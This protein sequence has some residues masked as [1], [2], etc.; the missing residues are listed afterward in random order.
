MFFTKLL[1]QQSQPQPPQPVTV[2]TP[3]FFK[4]VET[5]TNTVYFEDYYDNLS[6]YIS[7]DGATWTTWQK[8]YGLF[9][10]TIAPNAK[11]YIKAATDKGFIGNSNLASYFRLGN[12]AK[13]A[14]GGNIMSLIFNNFSTQTTITTPY[15]FARIF[16]TLKITDASELLLPATTVS[17]NCYQAL[18]ADTII[19]YAPTILPAT[20]LAQSCYT[21][22]FQ[23]C[24]VL[25]TAPELPATVMAQ[26]CYGAMFYGCSALRVAPELPAT[27]LAAGCYAQMFQGCVTLTNAPEL[28]AENL[29][30]ACYS[31]MFKGCSNLT[32]IKCMAS[33]TTVSGV[34]TDWTDGV[35]ATGTF[36]KRTSVSWTTGT[37]GIPTG[38]VVRE[39]GEAPITSATPFFI[40][41]LTSDKV[42]I[43]IKISGSPSS[44]T[45]YPQLMYSTNG[46]SWS[47]WGTWDWLSHTIPANARVYIKAA[48]NNGGFT[49][50]SSYYRY[51][52]AN[53]NI[54]IGGNILS[55]AYSNF[56]NQSNV[57][58]KYTFF[59]A[60]KNV[61]TLISASR[62]IL[63][64]STYDGCY[65]S[66]FN[67]C[68]G[69]I[70]APK[71]P[72]TYLYESCYMQMFSGCTSLTAA[73]PTLPATSLAN[74][75]YYAMFMNCTALTK[76]PTIGGVTNNFNCC[77]QMF[78][79][80]SNLKEIRLTG[81]FNSSQT[82]GWVEGVASTGD[83]YKPSNVTVPTGTNGI[84]TGWTVHNT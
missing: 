4:N 38:W 51:F 57:N 61:T 40:E 82:I 59:N 33:D 37:S 15:A 36:V 5:S 2:E 70:D 72:A 84:P 44:S 46:T 50:S 81:S 17:N 35:Y 18:L 73:P 71:L 83:F 13:M 6:F 45:Y 1:I 77:A 29:E 54:S 8:T 52:T 68:T 12:N 62:L 21:S 34:T 10:A 49:I 24:T 20:T 79:G 39:E 41:N 26:S 65:S 3:F 30:G 31:S 75:C 80:C 9:T 47:S 66:M 58:K 43:D 27:T 56:T 19:T 22:M 55:L 64:N 53:G 76:A 14:I 32:Y 28:P 7:S 11:L 16:Q 42:T 25:T 48:S 67:G 74:F 23:N 69:L 63:P 60:F 78:N